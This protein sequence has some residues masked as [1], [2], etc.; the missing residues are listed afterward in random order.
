MP[1]VRIPAQ[2]YAGWMTPH[3]TGGRLSTAILMAP[4][5]GE[6]GVH[7]PSGIA[8]SG[9]ARE[10]PDA[11]VVFAA[12]VFLVVGALFGY[13]LSR[14]LDPEPFKLMD[15]VSVIAVFYILAQAIER[16]VEP[17]TSARLFSW[18]VGDKKA[19]A[20]ERDQHLVT[21]LGTLDDPA[22]Q[23]NEAEQAANKQATVNRIRGNTAV[24][25]WGLA[26][27]LAMAGS[28]T[29]GIYLLRTIGVQSAP[30]W[31]DIAVTGLAIGAG[32]K[33][34]H[35]LIKLVQETKEKKHD[36]AEVTS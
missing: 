4:E 33:P 7:V 25:V 29:L 27:V 22:R 35:D 34:L 3:A 30:L 2:P 13:W 11:V 6:D 20:R 24:F 21:A 5:P 31:L 17:L 28:G 12:Y 14:R 9:D 15:G 1:I 23:K 8:A 18:V 32:T 16:F 19:E 26:S 36:P 10:T